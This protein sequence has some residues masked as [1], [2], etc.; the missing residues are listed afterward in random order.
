MPPENDHRL[1]NTQ[2]RWLPALASRGQGRAHRLFHPLC[3]ASPDTLI[4][5]L[6]K[7]GVSPPRAHV[8]AIA[9]CV[10]TLRLPFTLA[11]T[12]AT[13]G[14]SAFPAPIF[15]VGHWRSGT[16]HLTNLLSRSPAFGILSPMSVALPGEARGFARIVRPFIEQFFPR[17]RL[18]DDMPL[19]PDLPQE[20]ELA[21]ANLST[22]SCNHG[23]YFPSRLVDE[24][25]RGLFLDGVE[26]A[27]LRQWSRRLAAFLGK[28][29]R[30]GRPL[31]VRNPANSAR[32][33]LLRAIWPDARFIH[34][35]RAPQ[36]VCAS[37]M[38]MFATLIRELSL[39]GVTDAD[40]RARAL[41]RR[42]YP[43][44]MTRLLD[45]T[46]TLPPGQFVE[47]PYEA[48]R[49]QPIETLGRIHDKLRLPDFDA[50][51]AS[52][53]EQIR[54]TPA[55][56][57]SRAEAGAVELAWLAEHPGLF[58]RLGYPLPAAGADVPPGERQPEAA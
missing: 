22:L 24:F 35:H 15:I 39:G 42:V 12:L 18:I 34:I 10:T 26:E 21:M 29:T 27:E 44:L 36:D 51:R 31:L 1:D 50:M 47:V 9:L 19:R 45:D 8:A 5:L 53:A 49:S 4:R 58:A 46:A 55:H 43:R 16:T 40:G 57:P 41:V 6:S 17:T 30:D 3:G 14:Q 28:M 56:V 13:R 48:L 20:D 23:L 54:R 32:I 37:S 7:G 38:R 11:E 2:P 52:V 33:P 25:D